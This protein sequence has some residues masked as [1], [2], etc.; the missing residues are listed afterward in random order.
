[1]LRLGIGYVWIDGQTGVVVIPERWVGF[2]LRD[3]GGWGK[4]HG[5]EGVGWSRCLAVG[6]SMGY[7][8]VID[9]ACLGLVPWFGGSGRCKVMNRMD[10]CC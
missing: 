10:S 2:I 1:V 9:N 7:F 5:A 6:G 8:R 3:P 4:R